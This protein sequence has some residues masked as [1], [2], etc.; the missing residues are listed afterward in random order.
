MAKKAE[1]EYQVSRILDK[2]HKLH[3]W[4]KGKVAGGSDYE[5]NVIV[6]YLS[7]FSDSI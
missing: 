7:G 6:N 1:K 2:F 3:L 5:I 4:K